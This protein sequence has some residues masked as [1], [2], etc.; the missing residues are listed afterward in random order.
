VETI[1]DGDIPGLVFQF[2]FH[3]NRETIDIENLVR[4]LWFI[5]NHRQLR[6]GS[7]ARMENNSDRRNVLVFEVFFQ[8]LFRCFSNMDHLILLSLFWLIDPVSL[9]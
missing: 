4:V 7:P 5:Q 3:Q 6:P 9:L 2:L 1:V 8:N